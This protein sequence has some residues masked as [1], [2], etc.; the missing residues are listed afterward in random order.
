MDSM[1]RFIRLASEFTLL[2][3][4]RRTSEQNGPVHVALH[5]HRP[6]SAPQRPLPEQSNG[7][8]RARQSV[9]VNPELHA[10]TPVS[11]SHVPLPEQM[12]VRPPGH[13]PAQSDHDETHPWRGGRMQKIVEAKEQ[14]D[15]RLKIFIILLEISVK[16]SPDT[17]PQAESVVKIKIIRFYLR[18]LIIASA[19]L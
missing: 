2:I 15:L 6:S 16:K 11:A 17:R 19:H 3:L 12:L 5:A 8:V 18:W 14:G 1:A 13:T 10:H 7:Q 4:S 9:P